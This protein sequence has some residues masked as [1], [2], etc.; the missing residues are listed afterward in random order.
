MDSTSDVDALRQRVREWR[1]TGERIALVPT[2]GNLHEGHLALVR[3]G[4]ELADRVVVTIFVNPSQFGEGEDYSEYP[5][6]LAEDQQKLERVD[7]DLLFNPDVATVYPFGVERAA[8]VTVPRITSDLCGASRPGH[9][10]GVTS[11]VIRL[12]NFLQP[13]VAVFGEKDYQQLQV[14]KH[15]VADLGV[16]VEI[17][18]GPTQREE[19]GLALSSRNAYLSDTQRAAAPGLYATL[20]ETARAMQAGRSD[21]E[22]LEQEG[23]AALADLGFEPD[24]FAVRQ[25]RT[26]EPATRDDTELVVLAAARLGGTRLIDNIVVAV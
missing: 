8:R 20:L 7:A 6:T 26:L 21:F 2:M 4:K 10:D 17:V 24:Y 5:R 16:P 3:I 13:D 15:M 11:V 19:D 23:M 18:A 9:F 12:F 22:Q 14:I 25:S 1:S